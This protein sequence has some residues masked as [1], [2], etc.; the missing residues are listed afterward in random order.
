[1]PAAAVLLS[2]LAPFLYSQW[3]ALG[4]LMKDGTRNRPLGPAWVG[5]RS[6]LFCASRL[7]LWPG[8]RG[9]AAGPGGSLS[10][11]LAGRRVVGK[12]LEL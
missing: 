12:L 10:C 11:L 8:G 3:S 6:P 9:E 5:P 7:T 2:Q 4:T 1:M